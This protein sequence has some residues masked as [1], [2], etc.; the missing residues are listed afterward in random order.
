MGLSNCTLDARGQ[1]LGA[2][3]RGLESRRDGLQDL[4]CER[5]AAEGVVV[6]MNLLT[7]GRPTR[8]TACAEQLLIASSG[9]ECST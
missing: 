8:R 5:R 3:C 9:H 2:T 7:P 6:L 1:W 4:V